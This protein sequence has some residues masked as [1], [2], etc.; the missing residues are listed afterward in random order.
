MM[1]A[2][3]VLGNRGVSSQ[4]DVSVGLDLPSLIEN[5]PGYHELLQALDGK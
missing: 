3:F 4:L 5:Y 1:Q 2:M